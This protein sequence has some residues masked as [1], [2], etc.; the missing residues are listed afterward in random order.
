MKKNKAF[1]L[2][3]ILITLGIIGVVAA[4]T[5]P[6]LI[7]NSGAAKV[8]PS[9]ATFVTN[10]ENATQT[11]M[12]E[13]KMSNM[14][15]D[16]VH[17]TALADHLRM[18][19][20]QGTYKLYDATGTNEQKIDVLSRSAI[21][22]LINEILQNP[23]PGVSIN[24]VTRTVNVMRNG[25]QTWQ[26][27]NG[28]IMLVVPYNADAFDFR[29]G[30]QVGSYRGMAGEILLDIDGN[31]GVN[32]AGKDVFGFLLDKSGNLIPAG[33][34]AHR[35]TDYQ[36]LIYIRRYNENCKLESNIE[37]NFAC[38]GKIADNKYNAKDIL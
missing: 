12:A 16:A 4:L 5:A 22:E 28:A 35:F 7:N 11:M 33:S 23:V 27:K 31:T 25:V 3:E 36:G 8:G 14:K 37:E 9:L 20:Y 18:A 19:P 2:A 1:T 30:R 6:A 38:T 17:M 10:F 32:K 26:L 24:D 34:N 13:Q 21:Q 29:N 15:A